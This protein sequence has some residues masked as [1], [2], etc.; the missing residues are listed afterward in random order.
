M[1]V[2]ND[3]IDCTSRILSSSGVETPVSP[4]L[5][6]IFS[7]TVPLLLGVPVKIPVEAL[8][9][10]QEGSEAPVVVVAERVGVE[11]R[12]KKRFDGSA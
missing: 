12:S 6:E 11:S 9:V 3:E 5:A 1:G 8:N 10:N 2:L 7:A 4:S